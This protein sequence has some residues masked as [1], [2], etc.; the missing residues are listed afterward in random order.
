MKK[1]IVMLAVILSAASCSKEKEY[2]QKLEGEW[3]VYKM[4]RNNID[5][6]N[7]SPYR[8]TLRNYRITFSSGAFTECNQFVGDTIPVCIGGTWT[9]ENQFET[10]T[11][12]DSVYTSRSYTIF[13]LEGNHVELRRNGENRYFR[14]L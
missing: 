1:T 9:F 5:V 6:T 12:T 13:N 7:I 11:L 8:D 14:K 10:L 3:Y 4:L 2:T